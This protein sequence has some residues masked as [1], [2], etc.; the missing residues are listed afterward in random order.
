[1]M[2]AHRL[3]NFM[4]ADRIVVLKDGSIIEEGS[5]KELINIPDGML[6]K[7]AKDQ[8]LLRGHTYR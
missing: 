7:M 6:R 4:H 5:W 3:K 2:I 1:M 8:E